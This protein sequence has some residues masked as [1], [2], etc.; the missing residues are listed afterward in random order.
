MGVFGIEGVHEGEMGAGKICWR[1]ALAETSVSGGVRGQL[2]RVMAS[3]D[4]V[5]MSL[6]GVPQR[7]RK[8]A[9]MYQEKSPVA[10]SSYLYTGLT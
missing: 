6:S 4:L 10:R 5:N 7:G 3:E 2:S 8:A 9:M 1:R